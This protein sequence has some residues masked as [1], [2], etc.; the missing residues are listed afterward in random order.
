MPLGTFDNFLAAQLAGNENVW[1]WPIRGWFARTRLSPE[2]DLNAEESSTNEPHKQT[3]VFILFLPR[4]A[5][6]PGTSGNSGI[7]MTTTPSAHGIHKISGKSR[8]VEFSQGPTAYCSKRYC[9]SPSYNQVKKCPCHVLKK[10][11]NIF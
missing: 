8:L 7:T 6:E 3:S 9:T 11:K 5:I 2:R 1:F 10:K 4:S